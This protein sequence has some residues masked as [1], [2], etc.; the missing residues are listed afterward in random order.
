MSIAAVAAGV[1]LFTGI[2]DWRAKREPGKPPPEPLV[3]G[4]ETG[5]MPAMDEG[6]FVFDYW[7]PSGTPLEQTEKMAREVEKI[8]S[9]NPDIDSYVR[10]TGA[11]LG[12]FATQ[13][14]R[15]DIQVVLRPAD[16]D[17]VSLLTKPVRPP[18]EDLDKQLKA[19]GKKI[20]DPQVRD[21]VRRKYRRRPL[22][23]WTDRAGKKQPGVMDE[24]EDE[25][26]DNYA[27]H[28]LKIEL[29][30]IMAD[31]LSDL[32]GANKPIEIKIFGPDQKELRRL[33]TDV[34]E[35]LEKKGKGR[36]IKEVNTNVFEGNPDLMIQVDPAK[37]ERL[38]LKPDAIARQ[39]KAMF[40][41]QIAAQVQESS[42]RITA[43]PTSSSARTSCRSRSSRPTWT[44]PRRASVRSSPTSATGWPACRCRPI[45]AGNWAAITCTSRTRSAA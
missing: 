13:T 20:E 7:A 6:A 25:V 1:V 9:K 28:Q 4:L 45:T 32:S 23:G 36:G 40:L 35:M 44:K 2:P 37:A 24:I 5:L 30:Q 39:L 19:E 34:G 38:G 41:G 12:L 3:K 16:D 17:P 18:M 31:E 29:I 8:L 21:E 14:S 42:Q 43:R 33:A 22:S 10:R 15:G 11:E 26:K 27:E